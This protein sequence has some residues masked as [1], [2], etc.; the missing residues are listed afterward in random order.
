MATFVY[1]SNEIAEKEIKYN[2]IKNNEILKISLMKEVKDLCT[3][4]YDIL[5]KEIK[6]DKNKW[7]I[8]YVQE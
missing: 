2:H 1:I 7:K 5:M 8:S 3:E 6:E 4:N